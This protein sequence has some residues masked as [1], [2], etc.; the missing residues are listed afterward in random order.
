MSSL[1]EPRTIVLSDLHLGR[2]GGTAQSHRFAGLVARF[3]RVIVNGDVA[4]LHHGRF[5][6]AAEHELERLRHF[7]ESAGARLE[8]VAGNHDPFVS[9]TRALTLHDGAVYITHGDALHPAIAPW[10]PFAA[11]M[12]QAYMTALASSAAARDDHESRLAAAREASIAEWRAV[13]DGAHISTIASMAARPHRALAVLSYWRSYPSLVHDWAA[14]FA[15]NAGTVLVGHSHRAFVREFSG[16][17]IV[18]TGSYSFPGRPLAVVLEAGEARIHRVEM[19]K[20]LF[21][22]SAQPIA[23]WRLTRRDG[24]QSDRAPE[25]SAAVETHPPSTRRMNVAASASAA[26]SSEV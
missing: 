7:C 3:Q 6:S 15:P 26:R 18:N 4:E 17:R 22:L 21:E 23:S 13:G 19:E 11:A 1:E 8:L 25:S 14:R 5:R 10:S 2:P 20:R 9:A 16:V 12:R 24:S